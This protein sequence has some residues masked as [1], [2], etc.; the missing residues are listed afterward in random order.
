MNM[1]DLAEMNLASDVYDKCVLD[2]ILKQNF[3]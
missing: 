2:F 3:F 1:K